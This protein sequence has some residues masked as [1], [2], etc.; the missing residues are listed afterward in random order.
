LNGFF[1]EEHFEYS[2]SVK[3]LVELLLNKP[4]GFFEEEGSFR[5][6]KTIIRFFS[7]R[8]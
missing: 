4:K 8:N 1:E 7:N 3:Q 6:S 5:D 2:T